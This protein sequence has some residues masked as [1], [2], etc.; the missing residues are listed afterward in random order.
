MQYITFTDLRKET[1][2]LAKALERGEEVTLIKRSGLWA[3]LYR[4]VV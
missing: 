4:I 1:S 3:E 2:D